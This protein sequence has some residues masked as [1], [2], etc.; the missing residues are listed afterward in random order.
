MDGP[1]P[2]DDDRADAA[3]EARFASHPLMRPLR[4]MRRFGAFRVWIAA[5]VILYGLRATGNRVAAGLF[6]FVYLA[7]CLYGWIIPPL[8]R[9]WMGPA[10]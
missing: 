1:G 5:M 2:G 6:G 9:R 3:R 7:Y 4:P 10:R 8:V